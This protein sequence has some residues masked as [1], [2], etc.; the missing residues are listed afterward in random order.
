MPSGPSLRSIAFY[1]PQFHPIPENDAWWGTGF[2]EWTNVTKAR[3][4]FPG[5]RQPDLPGELGFYDLRVAEN[6]H[7]QAELARAY[8]V[9][10]FCYW[11]YWFGGG[12]RILERPITE[13]IESGEPDLGFCLG[14]ANESWSGVWHGA[15]DTILIE[16]TYP[17]AADEEAHFEAVL[18]AFRDPRYLTVDGRPIFYVFRPENLPDVAGFI[19]HWRALAEAAGLPGLYFVAEVTNRTEEEPTYATARIDGFD[20][21]V[22]M[23]LPALRRRGSARRVNL[24]RRLGMPESYPY[25][26]QPEP[27]PDFVDPDFFQPAVWPAWDNTPRS[28]RNGVVLTGSSPERFRTHVA[29][30]ARRARELPDGE[31]IVWVKSWNEWAEGNH[32]EPDRRWGRGWLEALAA[33]L[34]D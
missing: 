5:H 20:A 9:S 17:G 21:A 22:F 14:W 3:P 4:L 26:P 29:A 10:G 31:G 34:S 19:A 8:G 30:A 25:L 7:A 16:Q 1:L 12:R 13:V 28:G 2:T 23:R 11:H 6:R 15:K 32:L 33:G 18:P 27:L 24:S